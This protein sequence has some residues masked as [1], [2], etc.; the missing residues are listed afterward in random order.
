MNGRGLGVVGGGVNVRQGR[1]SGD[2]VVG[3]VGGERGV[4]RAWPL[5]EMTGVSL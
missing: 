4:V 2:G 3:D 1:L 5:W